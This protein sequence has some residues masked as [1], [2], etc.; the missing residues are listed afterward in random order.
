MGYKM[1]ALNKNTLTGDYQS[2]VNQNTLTGEH[3]SKVC[4][5]KLRI[6]NKGNRT[7]FKLFVQTPKETAKWRK[8]EQ[9]VVLNGFLY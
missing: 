5:K 4:L 7:V 6:K 1:G 3:Q 2:K 9:F 8:S